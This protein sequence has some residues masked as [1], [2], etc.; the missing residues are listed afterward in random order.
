LTERRDRAPQWLNQVL[1]LPFSQAEV[2]FVIPDLAGD[3]RLGIDPFLLFK[4]R[5]G[6]L[7]AEHERLLETFNFG[8][9]AL[10]RR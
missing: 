4:S 3:L 10:C 2:D 9:P 1:E 8:G 6:E 7:K 5:D